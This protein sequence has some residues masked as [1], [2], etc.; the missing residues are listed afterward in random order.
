MKAN[1]KQ[2]INISNIF[3]TRQVKLN[4]IN[5]EKIRVTSLQFIDMYFDK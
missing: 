1:Y 3:Y 5:Q 2:S 4:Q